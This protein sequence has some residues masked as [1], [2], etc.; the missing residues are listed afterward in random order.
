MPCYDPRGEREGL[1]EDL[2]AAR[3][4]LDTRTNQLCRAMEVLEKNG[5]LNA[6]R[7]TSRMRGWWT[8]HKEWDRKRKASEA[9][10]AKKEREHKAARRRALSK[11]S[12][13]DRKALG[14]S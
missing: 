2:R 4:S 11:L 8:E 1:A 3:K 7:I 6:P 10:A 14:L 13:A 5:L 12:A 9:R